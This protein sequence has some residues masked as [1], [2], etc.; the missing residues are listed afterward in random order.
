MPLRSPDRA[1]WS[2]AFMLWL[3]Q[4]RL[5]TAAG[6]FTLQ[7]LIL[8]LTETR[9]HNTN[10]LRQLRKEARH[11]DIAPIMKVLQGVPWRR[12]HY[13]DVSLHGNHGYETLRQ[14]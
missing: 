7:N 9:E 10:V 11:P 8:Q 6:D 4:Q 13:C 2:H 14:R 5:N 12:L 3:G 1:R